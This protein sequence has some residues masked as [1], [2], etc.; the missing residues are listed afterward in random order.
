MIDLIFFG[1]ISIFDIMSA[2]IKRVPFKTVEMLK[3]PE[4]DTN[5]SNKRKFKSMRIDL[6]LFEPTQDSFPEFSYKKMMHIE[7]VIIVL[8][9]SFFFDSIV[10][11]FFD[12][13][14]NKK[15]SKKI[16]FHFFRLFL[17]VFIFFVL[18]VFVEI[19]NIF[20]SFLK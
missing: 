14:H 4:K 1:T 6:K 8:F 15:P 16:F 12:S 13:T 5:G 20:F 2:E 19:L 17:C 18:I 7:K 3:K 9:P 10:D 11:F